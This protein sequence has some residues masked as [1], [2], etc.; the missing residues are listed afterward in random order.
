MS[1]KALKKIGLLFLLASLA[2]LFFHLVKLPRDAVATS[3]AANL[4]FKGGSG[5]TPATVVIIGGAPD[6]VAA[7][8]GEYLYLGNKFG[9]QGRDWQVVEKEDVPA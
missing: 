2:R 3:Q 9:K 1:Y 6:Y 7:V 5:D 8:A 4:T